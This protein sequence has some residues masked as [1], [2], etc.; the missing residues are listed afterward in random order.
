MN[1]AEM[2][3]ASKLAALL[4]QDLTQLPQPPKSFETSTAPSRDAAMQAEA[5]RL[6]SGNSLD[7]EK[8]NQSDPDDDG[9]SLIPA[10][11]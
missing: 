11:V 8:L 9:T 3:L 6:L 4:L 7:L 5:K 10:R 2:L 1:E